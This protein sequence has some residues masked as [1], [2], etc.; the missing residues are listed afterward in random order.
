M[1][2][3]I[4]SL[5]SIRN[6]HRWWAVP[7][8]VVVVALALSACGTS[9]PTVYRVGILS[10]VDRF[11]PIIDGFKAGMTDLGYIEDQDI[12]YDVQTTDRDLEAYR[13]ILQ[14]FVASDVDLILTFPTEAAVEAKAVTAGTDIPVLFSLAL[15]ESTDLVASVREPG[16]NLTGVRYPGPDVVIKRFEVLHDLMPE[17]T[18]ILVA[19]QAGHPMAT[20]Q[21]ESLRPIVQ[22]A[23]ISLVEVPATNATDLEAALETQETNNDPGVDAILI[24]A[25]PLVVTPE[26][27]V[28]L[29]RFAATYNLPVGGVPMSVDGYETLFGVTVDNLST[30]RQAA[31]LADK[32]LTGTPAGTIPVASAETFL[33]INYREAQRLG[34]T[35][36]E[37]LLNQANEI[38]R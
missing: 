14:D 12:V 3:I 11:S 30:G 9:K 27:F 24:I 2:V 36:P 7:L 28:V 32:I 33:T 13:R 38:I 1:P 15:I 37:G 26:P 34:M 16:G 5:H 18:R 29:S 17:A 23:G 31:P 22:E 20:L 21:L 10:G 6:I 8:W 19:Y 4:R 25:E 35:V